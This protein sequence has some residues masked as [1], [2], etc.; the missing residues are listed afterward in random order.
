M[1]DVDVGELVLSVDTALRDQLTTRYRRLAEAGELRVP[2]D[3]TSTAG[4]IVHSV[5]VPLTEVG[6]LLLD[7]APALAVERVRPGRLVV[8]P[9]HRPQPLPH[10]PG[11]FLLDVHLGS[12]ARRMR[13]L[14]LDVAY[15]RQADDDQ[16][17]AAAN[18]QE[19]MLLTQ[20]RGLLRRRALRLGAFVRGA[21]SAA[22]LDDVLDRFAPALAPWT[23]CP[24]CNAVLEVADRA[25]VEHLLEPGTRRTYATFSRCPACGRVYWRGAHARRL[26]AVVAHAQAVVRSR[27]GRG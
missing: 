8:L 3:P 9:V 20:D 16:L 12:L 5:G 10:D 18:D 25:Q 24:Q 23:R 26:D 21:G 4:H 19:R 2:A 15:E 17:V 1:N 27:A 14:G 22:Q 7:G 6:A 13:L 11:R